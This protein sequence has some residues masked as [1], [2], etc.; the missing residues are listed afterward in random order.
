MTAF[1]DGAILLV[2]AVVRFGFGLPPQSPA[3][4]IRRSA[5]PSR[6]QSPIFCHNSKSDFC[7]LYSR[8]P[9]VMPQSRVSRLLFA[10]IVIILSGIIG[11]NLYH[12][13]CNRALIAAVDAR[14]LPAVQSLLARGADVNTVQRLSDGKSRSL[15]AMVMSNL[16]SWTYAE[17][18]KMKGQ[19]AQGQ[20]AEAPIHLEDSETIACLL[21]EK[22]ANISPPN[23]R[24]ACAAGSLP[25]MRSLLARGADPNADYGA[26][27]D[28]AINYINSIPVSP[29]D[30]PEFIKQK[31][32]QRSERRLQMAN[33]LR[34]HGAHFTVPQ[35]AELDDAAGSKAVSKSSLPS[36]RRAVALEKLYRAVIAKDLQAMRQALAQGADPNGHS[37]TWGNSLM[38][39]AIYSRKVEIAKLLLEHRAKSAATLS[40]AVQYMP[41]IAPELLKRGADINA[42]DGL[43]LRTAL[44]ARRFNIVDEL[45]RRGANVNSP[46]T[47]LG[48]RKRPDWWDARTSEYPPPTQAAVPTNGP[49]IPPPKPKPKPKGEPV[50]QTPKLKILPFSPLMTAAGFA[51]EYEARLRKMGAFIGPDKATILID[52]ARSNRPDLFPKLLA[53]GADVNGT[54]RDGETALTQAIVYAPKGVAFLLEHGA[55]PNVVTILQQTPV[56]IAA[57]AGDAESIRLLLAH[58]AQ[59]NAHPARGHTALYWARK[60][61]HADIAALLQQAGAKAE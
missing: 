1:A 33:L 47:L 6:L 9:A 38:E 20:V 61:H 31:R 44:A 27:I 5:F 52:A 11:R 13:Y 35:L 48:S 39:L 43:P 57:G 26:A 2:D 55:N 3:F 23:L 60:H 10:L 15:L 21:I 54:E 50:P 18:Q 14:D 58:G 25:V 49:A 32:A 29:E 22:G 19:G 42:P 41:A 30:S 51:P 16:N 59:I 37:P 7:V 46:L 4:S 17:A 28:A 34:E 45:L 12:H 53:Y 24:A 56:I 40:I 8:E 36:D